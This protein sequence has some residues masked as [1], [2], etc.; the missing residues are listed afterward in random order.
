MRLDE[1]EVECVLGTYTR[2]WHVSYLP[3]SLLDFHVISSANLRNKKQSS[4]NHRDTLLPPRATP[5]PAMSVATAVVVASR[6]ALSTWTMTSR[7]WHNEVTN[8][9]LGHV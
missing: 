8:S 5:T 1:C 3:T 7:S 2:A 6:E 4:P 9:E